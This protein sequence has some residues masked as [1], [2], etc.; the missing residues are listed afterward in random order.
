VIE[1]RT[2]KDGLA[3]HYACGSFTDYESHL[4]FGDQEVWHGLATAD[5]SDLSPK[6][7]YWRKYITKRALPPRGKGQP[8][9]WTE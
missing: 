6:K 4:S 5:E 8:A 3:W 9:T 7:T 2:V 1:A